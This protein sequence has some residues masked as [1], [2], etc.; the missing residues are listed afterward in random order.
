MSWTA[1]PG[2]LEPKRKMQY[3]DELILYLSKN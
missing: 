3:Y 2:R 1:G